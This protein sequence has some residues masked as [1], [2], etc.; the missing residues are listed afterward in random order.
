MRGVGFSKYPISKTQ[1][2]HLVICDKC[3]SSTAI[4]V[5]CEIDYGLSKS[6]SNIMSHVQTHHKSEYDTFLLNKTKPVLPAT[7]K[8]IKQFYE[9]SSSLTSVCQKSNEV[10]Q[11]LK[12]I[13]CNHWPL[14]TVE[15][16][17]FR[18]YV[19][20]LSPK[21]SLFSRRQIADE[22][23]LEFLKCQN[24]ARTM[25]K[26]ICTS[27]KAAVTV[28]H[29]TSISNETYASFTVHVISERFEMVNMPFT[30]RKISGHTT[31]TDIATDVALM[32]ANANVAPTCIVT[33]CEPSM[34]AASRLM[35][36]GWQG[37]TNHRLEKVA[38]RIFDSPTHAHALKK[39]RQ[40][41]GHF[42]S[43]SQAN[44]Q[45]NKMTLLVMKK[46]YT[47]IQDV[48]TRWWST[49]SCCNR[50]LE[51]KGSLLALEQV[52]GGMYVPSECRLTSV[53]WSILDV[54]VGIL[55]PFMEA[56]KTLE[57]EKYV[58][59]SL[60]IPILFTIRRAIATKMACR[61]ISQETRSNLVK[62][63]AAFEQRFGTFDTTL[64][65]AT[66][67]HGN[68]IEGEKRQPCGFTES[69]CIASA[70]DIRTK[71][72]FWLPS[73]D[74]ARLNEVIIA[75]ATQL[76]SSQSPAR[77]TISVA[78]AHASA[79]KGG[80]VSFDEFSPPLLNAN[81]IPAADH[82]AQIAAECTRELLLFALV[83]QTSGCINDTNPLEWWCKNGSKFPLL[84]KVTRESL[85]TPSTSAASERLFSESGLVSTKKRNRL[86]HELIEELVFLGKWYAFE[87]A[88]PALVNSE[89]YMCE[90]TSRVFQLPHTHDV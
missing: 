17:M 57:G 35:P 78:V 33:D 39:A 48:E 23:R 67:Q 44:E 61:D 12:L 1:F 88:Y 34:V 82:D 15:S 54:C 58:T 32:C 49:W 6:T 45:L 19:K 37:C 80:G 47:T 20:C 11:L 87:K 3:A 59:A 43:S 41:A 64:P 25:F 73:R 52:E 28:D 4:A 46:S 26:K 16:P 5:H 62:V 55:E 66:E 29:W 13:V 53:E 72:R 40:V 60:T 18:D 84:A 22:L 21:A 71:S 65:P 90:K 76:S 86:L 79:A 38:K 31:S 27:G 42:H 81:S 2:Q 8:G 63:L 74:H 85:Q 30:I 10:T 70:L 75:K 83:P 14:S 50:L 77:Q 56:E 68:A 7:A 51:L 69:Q 24:K 9:V 36:H 89:C